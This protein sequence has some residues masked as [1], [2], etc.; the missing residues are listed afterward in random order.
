VGLDVRLDIARYLHRELGSDA[1]RPP[2]ILERLVSE[3][4][5]GKKTKQGFYAY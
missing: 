5:L 1:F 4:K 2:A 3:G